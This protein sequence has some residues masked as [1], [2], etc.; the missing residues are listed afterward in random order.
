MW[1][2]TWGRRSPSC[3]SSKSLLCTKWNKR[4]LFLVSN[5]SKGRNLWDH[6]SL[7]TCWP[8]PASA[9]P[10]MGDSG[11]R[12]KKRSLFAILYTF[13]GRS[14]AC[15]VRSLG[16]RDHGFESH[17]GHGCLM[18]V[19]VC[20][21]FCVCV[22]VAALRRADHPSKESY[23]L[24]LIKKLRT[25]NPMLQKREKAPK[26][27]SNEEEKENTFLAF[28]FMYYGHT[29]TV[30]SLTQLQTISLHWVINKFSLHFISWGAGAGLHH[31]WLQ[32][33]Q[34]TGS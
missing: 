1:G 25:L 6:R 15:T 32:K 11:L 9:L 7:T 13:L 27:G 17:S 4:I 19:Y 14:Q 26:C 24:S 8:A 30:D 31:S 12:E 10:D 20:A 18:F 28:V 23:R 29:P 2:M 33:T 34:V 3:T 22:Q 16:S 21:F 5:H